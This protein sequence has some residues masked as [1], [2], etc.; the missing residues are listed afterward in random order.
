MAKHGFHAALVEGDLSHLPF[1]DCSFDCAIAVASY[2]HIEGEASRAT[3]VNELRRVLRPAGEAFI[4]VWN[5]E[6]PRFRGTSRDQF[7]P[8]RIGDTILNR[9]YHLFAIDELEY[10]LTQGGFEIERIGS[11]TRPGDPSTQDV[12]NICALVKKPV[13]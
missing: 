3:A 7:V 6:Q 12:R 1:S 2:H 8:W 9:Y 10:V 11:G 13:G 4:S 5:Y